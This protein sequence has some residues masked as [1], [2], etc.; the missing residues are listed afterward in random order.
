MVR[1]S[2]WGTS[3]T[4]PATTRLSGLERGQVERRG[5]TQPDRVA[6]DR[7]REGHRSGQGRGEPVELEGHVSLGKARDDV[8]GVVAAHDV[9]E[10]VGTHEAGVDSPSQVAST[11]RHGQRRSRPA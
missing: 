2:S 11:A 8:P 4:L 6:R 3:P 1:A 10:V 9:G 5:T 7:Q